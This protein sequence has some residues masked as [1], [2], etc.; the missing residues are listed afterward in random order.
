MFVFQLKL[1]NQKLRRSRD[2]DK[3]KLST[4]VAELDR[5][6]YELFTKC[7]PKAEKT[8]QAVE[9]KRKD[10]EILKI[11]AVLRDANNN[12]NKQITRLTDEI[13]MICCQIKLASIC[14]Q[15]L[16]LS[17]YEYLATRVHCIQCIVYARQY[18]SYV[19]VYF[20]CRSGALY[21]KLM[22]AS[23]EAQKLQLELADRERENEQLRNQLL[24][25]SHQD[26]AR[27]VA[28]DQLSIGADVSDASANNLAGTSLLVLLLNTCTVAIVEQ[29][30]TV[31]RLQANSV[32]LHWN[33]L[34]PNP[35]PTE[36]E[37]ERL[38]QAVLRGSW[39]NVALLSEP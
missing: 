34:G 28:D 2:D 16:Y 9:M 29:I 6:K 20:G 32:C 25:A 21:E 27:Q 4:I 33:R 26:P 1:D 31:H 22:E 8:Q 3:L 23:Q 7:D 14:L 36:L 5:T 24:G 13:S 10:K 35:G 37:E 11:Q 38:E 39:G 17:M 15:G 12:Y 19:Q 18:Y 30:T